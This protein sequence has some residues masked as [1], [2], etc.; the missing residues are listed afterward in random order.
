MS[1]RVYKT[2]FL[3][4]ESRSSS[5]VLNI[6]PF[7]RNNQCFLQHF[8][9]ETGVQFKNNVDEVGKNIQITR[10][11]LSLKS[12]TLPE[13]FDLFT[14]HLKQVIVLLTQKFKEDS[15]FLLIKVS[16]QLFK[17][18]YFLSFKFLTNVIYN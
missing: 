13:K 4:A 2:L 1:H 5:A 12:S 16:W 3:L 18:I 17:V 8:A 6:F 14:C 10:Q 7:L 9:V 15:D 11:F